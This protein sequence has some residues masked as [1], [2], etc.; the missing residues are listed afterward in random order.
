MS[1]RFRPRSA[2]GCPSP[3]TSPNQDDESLTPQ[4]RAQLASPDSC[5]YLLDGPPRGLACLHCTQP[6]ARVS[7]QQ[8]RNV[9]I[10][11]CV[12]NIAINYL[13]DGTFG[14]DEVFLTD[15]ITELTRGGRRLFVSFYLSNGPAQRRYRSTRIDG[16][17][18]K[19]APWEF[20]Q[21]IQYDPVF[22]GQYQQ[23]VDRLVPVLR[24]AQQR[25]AV[26]SLVPALEDNLTN[27]AFKSMYDATLDVLPA[28]L[29]VSV[30]R[31]ACG[32]TCYDGNEVGVPD[33]VFKEVHTAS[34]YNVAGGGISTNDGVDYTSAASPSTGAE[35][36]LDALRSLRNAA[37]DNN[38]IFIL[39][40]AKRQG[41]SS[42][43]RQSG[44]PIPRERSYANISL[45]E[46]SELIAF[47][48]EGLY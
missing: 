25:G 41:L 30:G 28:S 45:R 44:Y 4:P 37:G 27:S 1:G 24:Y 31:N 35:T 18:T 36:T 29:L 5:D 15:E 9:L 33:G 34:P 12:K 10:S 11:S 16:F 32:Y 14:F 17:G 22:I 26:I 43:F 39:W 48:R 8:I 38:S 7:A 13:V 46:R 47:L 42:N 23:I 19:I 2:G 40:S 20:R 3:T 21:R 6:E